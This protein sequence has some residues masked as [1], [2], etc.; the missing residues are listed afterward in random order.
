[1][2][3]LKE[4]FQEIDAFCESYN[5]T[6][7]EIKG[8]HCFALKGYINLKNLEN[9]FCYESFQVEYRIELEGYYSEKKNYFSYP[10][11]LPRVILL[12]HTELKTEDYHINSENGL[13]CLAPDVECCYIL[14][15]DYNLFDF[16]EKLVFPFFAALFYKTKT[17]EWPYGD[18]SHYK[19]G[20]FNYYEL[21]I[22]VEKEFVL[23]GLKIIVGAERIER[24]DKCFCNSGKKYKKCHR[25][26]VEDILRKV[27]KRY[28][29]SDLETLLE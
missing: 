9:S 14:G 6:E 10:E 16:T 11:K 23:A 21:K 3:T 13:C 12:N 26:I 20:L 29:K 17:G 4:I 1:M 15:K 7:W 22:Q 18:Y 28:L 5:F 24:N 2:R 19:E 8:K 25:D 27:D